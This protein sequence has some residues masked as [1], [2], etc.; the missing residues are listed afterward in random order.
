MLTRLFAADLQ[1]RR[2]QD[3]R[4]HLSKPTLIEGI[5]LWFPKKGSWISKVIYDSFLIQTDIY[6]HTGS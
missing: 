4:V 2:I 1:L 6:I 5:D 3:D